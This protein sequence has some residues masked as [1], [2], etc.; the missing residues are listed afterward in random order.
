VKVLLLAGADKAVAKDRVGCPGDMC[1]YGEP[2]DA[3]FPI[4][5]ACELSPAVS[6]AAPLLPC[7]P[8]P[9]RLIVLL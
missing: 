4:F 2:Q 6:H 1:A 8:R 5:D 7:Q 9:L 3:I